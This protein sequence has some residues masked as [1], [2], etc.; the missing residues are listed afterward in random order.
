V[1]PRAALRLGAGRVRTP[2][3]GFTR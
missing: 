2:A 1:T 3:S